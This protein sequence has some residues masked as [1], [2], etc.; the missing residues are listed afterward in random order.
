MISVLQEAQNSVAG[1][2]ASIALAFPN[3]VTAG[4][5]LQVF[6]TFFS[7]TAGQTATCS[8]SLNGA[9][10]AYEAVRDVAHNTYAF[11]FVFNGSA[12]GANTA[13]V[14]YGGGSFSFGGI[15][16]R[17]IGQTVGLDPHTFAD[18]A[19]PGTAANAITTALLVPSKAPGLISALC[20]DIAS[21][22]LTVVAGTSS[23][24][25]STLSGWGNTSVA[26]TEQF[27]YTDT[28]AR[29][30]T[31]TDATKGAADA[32]ITLAGWFLEVPP[33]PIPFTQRQTFINDVSNQF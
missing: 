25:V 13:T 1:S 28:T 15:W 9:Y 10:P 12:A 16:I 11:Q 8:D 26:L 21:S 17:E 31:F 19:A 33:P 24:F 3:P 14:T 7:N 6:G 23:A 29:A 5:A 27:R 2:A 32:Y 30:A 4:S 22:P 18:Q 20:M